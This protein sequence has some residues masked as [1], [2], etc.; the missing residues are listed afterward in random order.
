M[1]NPSNNYNNL[2]TD[3]ICNMATK[4]VLT[5]KITIVERVILSNICDSGVLRYQR[6]REGIVVLPRYL[7]F[8]HNLA[9]PGII[10]ECTIPKMHI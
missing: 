9:S 6:S 10:F 3:Y 8:R 2:Q 5:L 1:P 4:K 7:A